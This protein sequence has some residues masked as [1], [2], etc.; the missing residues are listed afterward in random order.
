MAPELKSFIQLKSTQQQYTDVILLCSSSLVYHVW[1][2][3]FCVQRQ[4]AGQRL[5][6]LQ[7][8]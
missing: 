6:V 4:E 1:W 3:R 2:R 5:V 7:M 8:I